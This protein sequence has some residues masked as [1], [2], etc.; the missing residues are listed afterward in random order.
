[1]FYFGVILKTVTNVFDDYYF[2]ENTYLFMQ[3]FQYLFYFSWLIISFAVYFTVFYVTCNLSIAM[4]FCLDPIGEIGTK[5]G[6]HTVSHF[7]V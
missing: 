7:T 3:V 1:M 5:K 6:T 4:I 2:G